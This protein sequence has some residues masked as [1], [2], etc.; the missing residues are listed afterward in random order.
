VPDLPIE[1]LLVNGMIVRGAA[2]DANRLDI[3]AML[4]PAAAL[5]YRAGEVVLAR[6]DAVS[7]TSPR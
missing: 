2:D 3:R 1:R 7:E 6:V 4:S 5:P